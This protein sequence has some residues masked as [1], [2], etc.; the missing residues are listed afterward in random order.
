M[1]ARARSFWRALRHRS[2]FERGMDEEL[3]FHLESRTAHVVKQGL[4]GWKTRRAARGWSSGILKPGR[5][6]AATRADCAC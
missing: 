3:R 6:A 2:S 4:S 5:S 1:W